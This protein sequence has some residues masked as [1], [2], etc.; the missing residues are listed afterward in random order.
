M[1][2]EVGK[3]KVGK[4]GEKKGF[5]WGGSLERRWGMK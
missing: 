5:E 3:V 2:G 4:E 1:W